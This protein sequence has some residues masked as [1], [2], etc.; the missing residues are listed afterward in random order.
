M[1]DR[2]VRGAAQSGSYFCGQNTEGVLPSTVWDDLI[3]TFF[4]VFLGGSE[5]ERGFQ[6]TTARQRQGGVEVVGTTAPG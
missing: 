5:G 4:S 1:T 3:Q 2:R 6:C